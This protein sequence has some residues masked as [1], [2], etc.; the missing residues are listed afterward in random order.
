MEIGSGDVDWSDL[1]LDRE[2]WRAVV[3]AMIKPLGSI[4]CG[5]FLDQPRS[6]LLFG[7]DPAP[8]S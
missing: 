2:E 6:N 1:A 8:C 3:S 7:K 4:K 5:G